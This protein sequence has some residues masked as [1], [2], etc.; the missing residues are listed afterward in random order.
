M[1]ITSE[2]FRDRLP[3]IEKAIETS[4]FMAI[5]GEFTGLNASYRNISAFDTP[6]ERYDK[7]KDSA[8][9]EFNQE[10]CRYNISIIFRQFLLIQFG[11]STFHHNKTSDSYESRTYN[12]YVWPRPCARNAPDP[13][14]LCQTSSIDFLTNQNFD[15]NKL[16]KHGVSYLRPGEL[17]KLSD[18]LRGR[19]E[20]RR[21]SLQGQGGE[22]QVSQPITIPEDQEK[23]LAEV[24]EKITQFM[25]SE[26]QQ[27]E[28]EKCNG[29]QRRLI[30]QT[31]REKYKDLSLNSIN[32]SKGDRYRTKR[33]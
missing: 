27:I 24:H 13:R 14:F 3:E 5:D 10:C 33:L 16:F 26:D 9:Q 28:L 21:Q 8:R 12:F 7:V 1:E 20:Q 2:N 11:L 25:A 4:T 15:F 30:Y 32:N 29:F 6:A 19:Q 22:A 31:A 17:Q 23:F 18:T